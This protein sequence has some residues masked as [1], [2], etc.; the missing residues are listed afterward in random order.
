MKALREFLRELEG[1][2]GGPP[3]KLKQREAR[4]ARFGGPDFY[5]DLTGFA[6][7]WELCHPGLTQFRA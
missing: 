2:L 4:S 3:E 6:Q 7:D 5:G 1:F